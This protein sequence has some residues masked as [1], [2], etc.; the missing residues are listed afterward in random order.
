MEIQRHAT[1]RG[2]LFGDLSPSLVARVLGVLFQLID[3]VSLFGHDLV[4]SL[5]QRRH[6]TVGV[7]LFQQFGPALAQTLQHLAQTFDALAIGRTHA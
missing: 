2:H 3:G 4:E 7:T 5:R 1:F 6:T